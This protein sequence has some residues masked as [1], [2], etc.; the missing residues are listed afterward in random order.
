MRGGAEEE[1][2]GGVGRQGGFFAVRTRRMFF[3]P[4]FAV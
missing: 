3:Y 2:E 1:K 4:S